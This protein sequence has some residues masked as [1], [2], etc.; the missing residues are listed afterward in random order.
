MKKITL[1]NKNVWVDTI[2]GIVYSTKSGVEPL[3]IRLF[4]IDEFKAIKNC[5]STGDDKRVKREWLMAV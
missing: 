3:P 1:Q 2:T 5:L 4:S